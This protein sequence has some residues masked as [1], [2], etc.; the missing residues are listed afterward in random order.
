MIAIGCGRVGGNSGDRQIPTR[1]GIERDSAKLQETAPA[2]GIDGVGDLESQWGSRREVEANQTPAVQKQPHVTAS[3]RAGYRLSSLHATFFPCHRPVHDGHLRG[4][5]RCATGH[6]EAKYRHREHQ[7]QEVQ[8]R[9]PPNHRS[10]ANRHR[11]TP[12]FIQEEGRVR[13]HPETIMGGLQWQRTFALRFS[14]S[15]LT[16]LLMHWRRNTKP[17]SPAS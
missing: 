1:G 13:Q 15:Y 14:P 8:G 12:T 10:P 2:V 7:T 9:G 5:G 16:T 4:H 6:N 3:V 17:T 11:E